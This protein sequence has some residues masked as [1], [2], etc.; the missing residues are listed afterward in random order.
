MDNH[1][2][3]RSSRSL[4]ANVESVL[5][6]RLPVPENVQLF[7]QFEELSKIYAIDSP[8]VAR[9]QVSLA[10]GVFDGRKLQSANLLDDEED[11]DMEDANEFPIDSQ[12]LQSYKQQAGAARKTS[13]QPQ[14]TDGEKSSATK[15]RVSGNGK[16]SGSFGWCKLLRLTQSGKRKAISCITASETHP[17]LLTASHLAN[18][19]SI[20]S[21]LAN[22]TLNATWS[23]PLTPVTS[24]DA[25]SSMLAEN[26]GPQAFRSTGNR[27]KNKLD[28]ELQA[29]ANQLITGLASRLL[30]GGRTGSESAQMM[31][32]N[33]YEWSSSSAAVPLISSDLLLAETSSVSVC[34]MNKRSA[35]LYNDEAEEA[36]KWAQLLLRLDELRFRLRNSAASNPKLSS[37]SKFLHS[38]EVEAKFNRLFERRI[39]SLIRKQEAK[40]SKANKFTKLTKEQSEKLIELTKNNLNHLIDAQLLLRNKLASEQ[41]QAHAQ[42]QSMLINSMALIQKGREYELLLKNNFNLLK[43]WQNLEETKR[44]VCFV[45]EPIK[46]NLGD[47]FWFTRK[48]YNIFSGH[49]NYIYTQASMS[50]SHLVS[51]QVCLDSLQVKRGLLQVSYIICNYIIIAN[52]INREQLCY[53]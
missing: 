23:P 18:S 17:D 2:Q 20:N 41:Q 21:T 36:R 10:F 29:E 7:D 31:I 28:D 39:N 26:L 11:G 33:A 47:L 49:G 38:P 45:S 24:S 43:I 25:I 1:N 4:N 6:Q 37:D 16:S 30:A 5:I 44:L 51:P 9:T 32:E 52:L 34:L 8:F 40:S 48:Q 53:V 13:G 27:N 15:K 50:Q 22:A 19:S 46:A 35:H 3:Q 42:N 12:V 14:Q